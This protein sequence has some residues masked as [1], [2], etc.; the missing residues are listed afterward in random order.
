MAHGGR[1]KGVPS[2]GSG[3]KGKTLATANALL[4]TPAMRRVSTRLTWVRQGRLV[5]FGGMVVASGVGSYGE[6]QESAT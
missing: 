1:E 2:P 5:G 4:E 3:R 6:G